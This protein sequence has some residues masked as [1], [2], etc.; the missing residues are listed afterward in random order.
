MAFAQGLRLV[1]L[2]ARL[3]ARLEHGEQRADG[4]EVPGDVLPGDARHDGLALE[5]DEVGD[6]VDVL[7][8]QG[9]EQRGFL[10][11]SLIEPGRHEGLPAELS[12]GYV[13]DTRAGHRR[14]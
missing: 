10:L 1:A 8:E 5:R 13:D 11:A 2:A 14:G 6:R 12:L 4:A 7:L 9:L 3:E